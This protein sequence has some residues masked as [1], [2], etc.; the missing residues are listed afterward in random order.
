MTGRVALSSSRPLGWL[1]RWQLAMKL[2]S[3]VLAMTRDECV[4]AERSSA[5]GNWSWVALSGI[6]RDL[7]SH[8]T[9]QV[10][11]DGLDG[12]CGHELC[13][14]VG[15]DGHLDPQVASRGLSTTTA[16]FVLLRTRCF[17]LSGSP[18][19]CTGGRVCLDRLEMNA[20]IPNARQ[21]CD[22]IVV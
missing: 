11:N 15:A 5:N 3:T 7:E 6:G 20:G 12:I 8:K 16:N 9:R 19:G 14:A 10:C 17:E 22:A 1:I 18:Y 13:Y 4:D 2:R 21:S